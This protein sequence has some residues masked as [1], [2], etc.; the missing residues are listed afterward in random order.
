MPGTSGWGTDGHAG[1]SVVCEVVARRETVEEISG[2]GD[3]LSDH[4]AW[5]ACERHAMS[6][7]PHALFHRADAT[8][9]LPDVGVGGGDVQGSGGEIAANALEFLIGMHVA[10]VETAVRVGLDDLREA[11]EHRGAG[12][13]P[14][15]EGVAVADLTVDNV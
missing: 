15:G 1:F 11:L 2:L 9:D 13:V 5:Q 10:D 3:E 8:F 6:G 12:P 14:D 7:G 4:E